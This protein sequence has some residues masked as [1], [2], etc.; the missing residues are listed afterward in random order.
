[1]SRKNAFFL[2]CTVLW[3]ACGNQQQAP[4][5][6]ISNPAGADREEL[7]SI[8]YAEFTDAFG[9]DSAFR[10]VDQAS[11]EEIPYQLETRGSGEAQAVLLYVHVPASGEVT[12][13]VEP[14]EPAPVKARTFARYVPERFDDFAWENDMVAFRMYGK[15]L[16]GRPDDAQGLDLWSK[17]TADLVIDKWYAHGDY[18][19]D[20]GEGMDYYSVGQTLGAGDIAPLVDGQLAYAKHYR[21]YEILD[22]GPLRTTFRLDY[23]PW[24]AGDKTVS[25]SKLYSLDA[26]AQLN[27]VEVTYKVDG[28]GRVPVAVGIA[29]RNGEGALLKDPGT[30]VRGYWE[31]EHPEHGV[32]GVGIV[33]EDDTFESDIDEPT[34]YLAVLTAENEQPIVYYNGGAWNRAGRFSTADEWFDYLKTHREKLAAPLMVTIN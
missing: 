13:A 24:K 26:G 14:G 15:A 21:T 16:E 32:T 11:G 18:H 17:R 5:I 22:N 2:L 33:L 29:R 30:G 9:N 27:R 34:Q 1:M 12:L 20:H 19:T 28:D 4:K 10:V 8:P 25:V 23:E 7:V 6:V 3:L 31:P